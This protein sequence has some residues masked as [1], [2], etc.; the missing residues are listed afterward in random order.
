MGV[1]SAQLL[2]SYATS[3]KSLP[4]SEPQFP[5]LYHVANDIYAHKCGR[6]IIG[7]Q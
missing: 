3:N 5:L 7:V 4:L 1:I 2:T 6:Y